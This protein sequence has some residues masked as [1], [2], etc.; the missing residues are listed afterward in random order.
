MLERNMDPSSDDNQYLVLTQ[1]EEEEEGN[2]EVINYWSE[3]DG[4]WFFNEVRRDFL[5]EGKVLYDITK[6]MRI[7][8]PLE[9]GGLVR[10]VEGF[11]WKEG[12][13]EERQTLKKKEDKIHRACCRAI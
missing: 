8:K 7:W 2:D 11:V 10:R 13:G 9:K 1:D 4:D 5:N 6:A 12:R 3:D